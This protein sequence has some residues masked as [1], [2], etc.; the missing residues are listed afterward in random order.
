MK[1]FGKTEEIAKVAAFL[2]SDDS[3]FMTGQSVIVDGGIT[4]AYT[5]KGESQ[6]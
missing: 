5:T 6:L 2:L 4:S 3:S 1:R